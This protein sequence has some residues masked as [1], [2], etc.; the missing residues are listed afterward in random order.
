MK[1]LEA[2]LLEERLPEGWE[3]RIL[4]PYGLTIITFNFTVK[5]VEGGIDEAK[6]LADK[7]ARAAEEG[8]ERGSTNKQ[9]EPD[10]SAG[11]LD[12]GTAGTAPK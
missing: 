4:K 3:S 10:S 9:D 1:D 5:K 7:A 8:S 11:A 2:V 12:N 6:Y